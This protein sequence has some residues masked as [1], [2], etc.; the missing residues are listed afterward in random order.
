MKY[1][2]Q[3]TVKYKVLEVFACLFHAELCSAQIL[4]VMQVTSVLEVS[5]LLVFCGQFCKKYLDFITFHAGNN[6]FG[7][8]TSQRFRK[9]GIASLLFSLW[10]SVKT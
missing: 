8:L 6:V 2:L 1:W 3:F 7:E 9:H 5:V 4:V 10:Q